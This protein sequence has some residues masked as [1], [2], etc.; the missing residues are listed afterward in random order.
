MREQIER[1]LLSTS[2]APNTALQTRPI[3]VVGVAQRSGTH[4]LQDL[5]CLH[6][7]C[8]RP[9][10]ARTPA[11]SDWEDYLILFGDR[12]E[13]FRSQLFSNWEW[14]ALGDERLQSI[15]DDTLARW[16][17]DF[18]A[19]LGGSGRTVAKSPSS[20]N[21]DRLHPWLLRDVDVVAV[22]RD[23]RAVLQSARLTFMD[24]FERRLRAYVRSARAIL[25]ARD[26]GVVVVRYEDLL[27]K[28]GETLRTLLDAVGLDSSAYDYEAADNLPI[29]GSATNEAD[30]RWDESPAGASFDGARRGAQ[31]PAHLRRRVEWVAAA[32]MQ[33]FG[34]GNLHPVRPMQRLELLGRDGA[35]RLARKA[36]RVG[37]ALVKTERFVYSAKTS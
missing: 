11:G 19:T 14:Q 28:R 3:L 10:S 36:S 5:L 33:A 16:V 1:T 13:D 7:A 21:L 6:P 9:V 23:P 34:Y 12:L 32:E 22:V 4:L 37:S 20:E 30:R 24:S 15:F 17:A 27:E 8:C 35:Y 25:G 31:L 29:R 18:F 26:K 2:V